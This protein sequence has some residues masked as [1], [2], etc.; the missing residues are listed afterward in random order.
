MTQTPNPIEDQKIGAEALRDIVSFVVV[1]VFIAGV[2]IFAQGM[3]HHIQ[4]IRHI[5]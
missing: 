3:A 1:M 2:S 5:L 4:H